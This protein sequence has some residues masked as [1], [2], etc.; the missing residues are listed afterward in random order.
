M[1]I[2]KI[3]YKLKCGPH[4]IDRTNLNWIYFNNIKFFNQ[5]ENFDRM[6][7]NLHKFLPIDKRILINN[8]FSKLSRRI[9]F[10]DIGREINRVELN[11]VIFQNY[12]TA[13]EILV[14]QSRLYEKILEVPEYEAI[15]LIVVDGLSYERA[16]KYFDCEPILVDGISKTENGMKRIVGKDYTLAARMLDQGRENVY[17]YSYWSRNENELTEP[18]FAPI[19]EEDLFVYKEFSEVVSDLKKKDINQGYVQI[20]LNGLDSISHR[21]RD[22]PYLDHILKDL[23]EKLRMIE[24]LC[25]NK[26]I[27]STIFMTSDHGIL[28]TKNN[29]LKVSDD[30]NLKDKG[31]RYTSGKI[32]RRITKVFDN[33]NFTALK[34]PYITEKIRRNEWGVHG[35]LSYEENV[36][37]LI[38]RVV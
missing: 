22:K 8:N 35:G 16:K 4:I 34:Y 38:K 23:K 19:P 12:D 28:W 24:N 30:F 33:E 9:P 26:K 29:E 11:K 17:G 21:H 2:D 15:F 1:D 36:V 6:I 14:N 13:K 18:I 20:I 3:N 7:D 37:P 27:N 31:K 25:K 5:S 32:H 10:I